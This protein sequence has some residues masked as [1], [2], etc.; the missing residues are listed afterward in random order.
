M[1]KKFYISY[2]IKIKIFG[3]KDW[4]TFLHSRVKNSL[5]VNANIQEVVPTKDNTTSYKG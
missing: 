3:K 5:L 2:K 4:G 1:V